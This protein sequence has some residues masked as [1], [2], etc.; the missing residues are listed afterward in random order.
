MAAYK[1]IFEFLSLNGSLLIRWKNF[2]EFE[3]TWEL[4]P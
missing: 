1:E 4:L 3:A 2:P